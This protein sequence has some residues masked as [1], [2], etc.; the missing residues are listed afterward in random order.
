MNYELGIM[1]YEC[2]Y[3]GECAG[4]ETDLFPLRTPQS[5]LRMPAP[6]QGRQA[7]E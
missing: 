3:A 1:N 2:W 7:D 4:I 6:L 5:S